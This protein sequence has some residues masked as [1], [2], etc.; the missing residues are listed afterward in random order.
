MERVHRTHVALLVGL[1]F[2]IASVAILKGDLVV[3]AF[4]EVWAIESRS[5]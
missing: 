1:L 3:D 5:Y 2:F 4:K